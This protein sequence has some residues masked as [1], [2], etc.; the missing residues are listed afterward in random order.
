MGET[1]ETPGMVRWDSGRCHYFLKRIGT[2]YEVHKHNT[3]VLGLEILLG[4]EQRHEFATSIEFSN[5][6]AL[7]LIDRIAKF[8]GMPTYTAQL[9]RWALIEDVLDSMERTN[10]PKS[11]LIGKIR[12][13]LKVT[14]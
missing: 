1:I 8:N 3:F 12:Q 9:Q 14:K 5:E 2:K 11:A 6:G 7:E 4:P 13:I 10:Q